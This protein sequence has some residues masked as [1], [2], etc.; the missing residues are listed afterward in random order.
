MNI[1]T[2]A[3]KALNDHSE[4]K[5]DYIMFYQY[6]EMFPDFAALRQSHPELNY[7]EESLF[8][9]YKVIKDYFGEE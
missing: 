5:H 4:D 9:I 8:S 1:I 3:Y 6:L 2:L 7:T